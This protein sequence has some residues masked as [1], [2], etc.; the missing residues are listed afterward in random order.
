[1]TSKVNVIRELNGHSGCKVLLINKGN[2]LFVR[3]IS[4]KF[5]YNDRLKKQ[6]N[7]QSLFKDSEFNTASIYDEG[8]LD[9]LFFFD[10]EYIN[11]IS[12]NS[13]VSQSPFKKSL[14]IFAQILAFIQ[15]KIK[16][17]YTDY[18]DVI[19]Q[20]LDTI[21]LNFYLP[22]LKLSDKNTILNGGYCHGDFTFENIIL[23]KGN[24]Y[25]IDFL[26]S[27][28]ESPI[29]DI[30]KIKQDLTLNW[31][32]RRTKSDPLDLIKND[33]LLAELGQFI[34]S[35][36]LSEKAIDLQHQIALLRILPYTSSPVTQ[37][38]ILEKI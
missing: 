29:I 1:M 3:K 19:K 38:K 26:D 10:M 23:S 4:P 30:A 33:K 32:N 36:N 7:K 21:Q 27:Y 37:L 13:F 8:Y 5:E 15:R 9:G 31:S 22:E 20:K 17:T 6:F 25:L 18:A 12:F 2:T 28:I 35:Q 24:I 11:G 14:E 34:F 16:Y